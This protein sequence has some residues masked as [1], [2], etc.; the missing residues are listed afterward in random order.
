MLVLVRLPPNCTEDYYA[1]LVRSTGMVAYDLKTRLRPGQWG[2]L[3]AVASFAEAE[4]V[5]ATL[6]HEG[7]CAHVIDSSLVTEPE[8][9][10]V[11]VESVSKTE[12]ELGLLVATRWMT[13][14]LAALLVMVRGELREGDA[15]TVRGTATSSSARLRAVVPAGGDLDVPHVQTAGPG[16]DADPV[17]DL[18]FVTVPW[19]AR[20]DS[21]V[22]DLG[23]FGLPP[24]RAESLDRVATLLSDAS[25]VRVDRGA[26]LSSL[27]SYTDR[28]VRGAS[29]APGG[30]TPPGSGRVRGVVD[31]RFD[32]YSLMVA[33]AE[34]L[35]YD[36]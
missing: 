26:R 35:A 28:A 1:K 4:D 13:V 10:I 30:S 12:T 16:P 36:A 11:A 27:W 29:R 2:V 3:R 9:A 7:L 23:A 5:A 25:G 18:H 19:V 20:L 33:A 31:P 34:R 32:A 6:R 8:R 14:P 15:A 21:R 17:L 22:T 24:R